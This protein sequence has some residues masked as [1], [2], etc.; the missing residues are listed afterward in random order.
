MTAVLIL[1]K[2][3]SLI[4]NLNK[5]QFVTPLETAFIVESGSEWRYSLPKPTYLV[6]SKDVDVQEISI[7]V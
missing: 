1:D 3:V 7:S 4:P 5:I 6:L 2:I